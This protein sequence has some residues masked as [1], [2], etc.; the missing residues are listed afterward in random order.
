MKD[1][2]KKG[3]RTLGRE[4]AFQILYGSNFSKEENI[5][6]YLKE[7]DHFFPSQK[8]DNKIKKAT[9]FA[10]ELIKHT[11]KNKNRLDQIIKSHSKNWKINRI[12]KVELTILRLGIYEMLYRDDV[13]LKVAI[14]EAIELSKRFGDSK[15]RKFVNGILD[16]TYKSISD[17]LKNSQETGNGE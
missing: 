15:S 4:I 3:I 12:A 16:A 8:K 10:K 6:Q 17:K 11:L 2:K 5:E 1:K 9:E 14:D 13:P 7:V